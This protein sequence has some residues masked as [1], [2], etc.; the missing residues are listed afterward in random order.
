M[1]ELPWVRFYPSD[2]L[3]GTRGLSA[4]ETGI[5]ITL[6]AMMYERGAPLPE[7]APRL[8]R[9]CGASLPRFQNALR[10]LVEGRKIERTPEGLW[11]RRVEKEQEKRSKTQLNSVN[12]ANKRWAKDQRKQWGPRAVAMPEQSGRNAIPETRKITSSLTESEPV[13]KSSEVR[14][15][16]LAAALRRMGRLKDGKDDEEAA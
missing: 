8:A 11:N 4:V 14:G 10:G 1:S 7:D 12:A 16:K 3:A 5:Y 9:L 6:I 15:E 13:E 2:W